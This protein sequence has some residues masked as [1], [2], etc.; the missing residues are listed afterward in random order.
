[1]R[2]PLLSLILLGGAALLA[3]GGS[4]AE[5]APAMRPALDIAPM[6]VSGGSDLHAQPVQ[7]YRRDELRRREEWRRREE[8]RRREM[9][10]RRHGY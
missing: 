5:A 9:W 7:Y 2:A 8:R 1:M 10:R 3:G 6:V 4:R